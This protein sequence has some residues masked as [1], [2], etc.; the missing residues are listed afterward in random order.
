MRFDNTDAATALAGIAGGATPAER[1]R[2]GGCGI[3]SRDAT[4]RVEIS[5][6]NEK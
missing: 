1:L 4:H 3:P 5:G 6:R 2:A